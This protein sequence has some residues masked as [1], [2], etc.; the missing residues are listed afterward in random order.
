MTVKDVLRQALYDAIDWQ[1]SLGQCYEPGTPER[2]EAAAQA[3]LYRDI[4]KRRY[5]SRL[6][7]LEKPILGAEVVGID[8][9][10]AMA[11][12]RASPEA[13]SEVASEGSV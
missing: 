3:K 13:S 4:L 5:G 12:E 10:R 1:R 6:T 2:A 9:L 11:K 7:P 8:E